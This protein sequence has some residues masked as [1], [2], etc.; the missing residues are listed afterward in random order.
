MVKIGADVWF[1]GGAD[2]FIVAGEKGYLENYVS[3]EEKEWI[4]DLLEMTSGQVFL[5]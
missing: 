3:P 4:R 1:G 2:S 5:S